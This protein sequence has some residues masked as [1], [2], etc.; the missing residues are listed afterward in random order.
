MTVDWPT[1]E[2]FAISVDDAIIGVI[3]RALLPPMAT[4]HGFHELRVSHR[5]RPASPSWS[6]ST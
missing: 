2:P 3:G 4:P 6:A 1:E 5:T